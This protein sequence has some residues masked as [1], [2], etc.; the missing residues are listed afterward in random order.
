MGHS[1]NNLRFLTKGSTPFQ[2]QENNKRSQNWVTTRGDKTLTSAGNEKKN[3]QK[4]KSGLWS[5]VS[6][7]SLGGAR[8]MPIDWLIVG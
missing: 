3:F 4:I 5:G 8:N 6:G 1:S 2:K 7:G